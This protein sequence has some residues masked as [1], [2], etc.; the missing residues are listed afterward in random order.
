MIAGPEASAITFARMAKYPEPGWNVPRL[1]QHSPDGKLVTYLTSEKGDEKMSLFALDVKAGT[2]E[3]ILRDA[4]LV[5]PNA[6]GTEAFSRDEELRRERQRDRNEG[7]TQYTWATRAP[8]LV[9]PHRGD[10]F[11]RDGR[12]GK[13]GA[14]HPLT[15]TP[16]P[17]LDAKACATGDR[18][19]FVRK[20]ELVVVD[21]TTGKE[22]FATKGAAEGLTHGLSDFNGQEELDEPSGYFWSPKC[23]RIAYLEVDERPV[24]TVPVLGYRNGAPELMMQRYPRS[25]EKNP[26]VRAGIVDLAT[27]K[28]TWLRM[29][30]TAEHYLGR[31]TWKDDGSALFLQTLT[32]DQKHLSLLR[33]DPKTGATTELVTESSAAWESFSPMRLLEKSDAFLFTSTKTGH[34]HLELRSA[35]DGALTKTLTEGAWDVESLAGVDEERDRALVTGTRDGPLERHL[36]AVPLGSNAAGNATGEPAKITRLTPERG[37]HDV[38]VDE[39]GKLWVDVHS[40]SDRP[41]RA[42]VMDEND[43]KV[44]QLPAHSEDDLTSLGIRAPKLVTVQSATGETLH[45]ALLAPVGAA[46]K[47]PA[48]V[49]VYGGPGAQ[50]V[51]DRWSPRLLWQ[52]LTDR[53]F[54][55]FQLD[56]RGSSGRGPAFS[57]LVHRRLGKLELEDQIA[58][59]KYLA[60]LPFVDASRIGIYG[61][62]YGGFL[63]S[64]AMLEG[65]GIFKAAVAGAPVTDWRL[66]DTAYTERYMETPAQNPEGYAAADLSKKAASLSGRL[67]LLH[68]QMDENVHYQNTAQLVD[69]LVTAG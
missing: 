35:R 43:T 45:G 41:P 63:A 33:V 68:A 44:A 17:E 55:V 49:M 1:V 65:G 7:I 40:A 27:K 11:V 8:V 48:I 59:A 47:H 13:N 42:I 5:D 52:H 66:Y 29:L 15:T 6:A 30:D 22:L 64:L 54:V 46:G 14:I 31:F 9:V 36:Y 56:N 26:I 37:V 57:Q 38:H 32:R 51:L 18:V 3:V 2:I 62:S 24:S 39:S 28:T 23:D 69:A 25:G 53:G 10:V 61:H 21:T 60:T 58:G 50:L 4:D 12:P 20:G 34:T 19:A 16:E 67:L